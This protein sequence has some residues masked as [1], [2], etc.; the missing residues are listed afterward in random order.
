M[1][2]ISILATL[3]TAI[4]LQGC[5]TIPP[6]VLVPIVV[7][8]PAVTCAYFMTEQVNYMEEGFLN[9]ARKNSQFQGVWNPTPEL[10]V[11]MA[12]TIDAQGGKARACSDLVGATDLQN[13]V[14]KSVAPYIVGPF[15]NDP[16]PALEL[17]EPQLKENGRLVELIMTNLAVGNPALASARLQT[18]AYVRVTDL[19]TKTAVYSARN[20]IYRKVNSNGKGIREMAEGN[21]LEMLKT[22]SHDVVRAIPLINWCELSIPWGNCIPHQLDKA[23]PRDQ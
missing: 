9:E 20:I 15:T 4:L 8:S 21:N 18:T 23:E 22:F 5:L 2:K 17:I 1:R 14:S 13:Y 3:G 7:S 16:S 6:R 12:K 19:S 11:E 10:S